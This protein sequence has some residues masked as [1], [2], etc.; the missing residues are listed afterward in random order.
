MKVLRPRD[1]RRRT[2][3]S[4][5]GGYAGLIGHLM[6]QLENDLESRRSGVGNEEG[7]A[8]HGTADWSVMAGNA[9]EVGIGEIRDREFVERRRARHAGVAQVQEWAD[10]AGDPRANT[11]VSTASNSIVASPSSA[12]QGPMCGAVRYISEW[13]QETGCGSQQRG[14]SPTVKRRAR[15]GRPRACHPSRITRR[16]AALRSALRFA[17][18]PMRSQRGARAPMPARENA[19]ARDPIRPRA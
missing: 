18:W 1:R 10:H 4:A 3:V 5:T 13:V 8:C 16:D 17:R 6:T 19:R 12:P 14:M 15:A 9:R 7:C 11:K 2:G